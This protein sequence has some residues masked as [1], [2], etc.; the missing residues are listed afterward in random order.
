MGIVLNLLSLPNRIILLDSLIDV[1]R[2]CVSVQACFYS[3]LVWTLKVDL[4]W[5]EKRKRSR[6]HNKQDGGASSNR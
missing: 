6:R 4:H 5:L 1:M 2:F 3:Y